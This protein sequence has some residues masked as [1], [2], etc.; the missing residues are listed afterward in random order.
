MARKNTNKKQL[1]GR[2]AIFI[3]AL[4]LICTFIF[5]N[6]QL[7]SGSIKRFA[8]W[9]FNG[10]R[11][12]A[13]EVSITFDAKEFNR[14]SLISKNLLVVSPDEISTYLLSGKTALNTPVI[15]RNPAVSIA[16]N[17]F[18]A[19]DLGGLNFYIGNSKKLL[20]TGTTESK[21]VNANMNKTGY[22][23]IITDDEDSKSLVTVYNPSFEPF[24]KFHSA[25]KYVFDAAVSP[26]G[27]SAAVVTYGTNEGQFESSLALCRTNEDGF[28][29]TVSLGDSMPLRVSYHSEKKLFLVCNDRTILFANDGSTISELSYN[30]LPIKSFSQSFGNHVAIALDNYA[31]GGNTR[32][33]FIKANGNVSECLDFDEDIYSISSA[34]DFTAVQ[35]SDKC[36]VYKNDLTLHSEFAISADVSRCLVNSDGS[37]ICVADNFATLYVK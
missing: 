14:F 21:L 10:A 28:Y 17:R 36:A 20:F 27:K 18:M 11:G 23:S 31:N 35:F 34:G 6:N 9:V 15:L 7:S 5:F 26:S 19:Y 8:Y 33:Y 37:V 32:L 30:A 25:E 4:L 3:T 12:D 1:S 29:T 24:Y 2:F 13:K 22:F 16:G